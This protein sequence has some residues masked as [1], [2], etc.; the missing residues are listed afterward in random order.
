MFLG[1]SLVQAGSQVSEKCLRLSL[2]IRPIWGSSRSSVAHDQTPLLHTTF[3]GCYIISS[4]YP[5]LQNPFPCSSIMSVLIGFVHMYWVTQISAGHPTSRSHFVSLAQL[6]KSYT[7]T[8]V[9]KCTHYNTSWS[10]TEGSSMWSQP[11]LACY[12]P[13]SAVLYCCP[14]ETSSGTQC[15]IPALTLPGAQG[16]CSQAARSCHTGFCPE[17]ENV[18][19]LYST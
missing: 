9:H 16:G 10:P 3:K 15:L 14:G 8:L 5:G 19:V 18:L 17:A 4:V 1:H 13:T 2:A 11:R 6:V 12:H 7:Q